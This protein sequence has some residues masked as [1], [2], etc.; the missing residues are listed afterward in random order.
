MI[1]KRNSL[2]KGVSIAETVIALA[3][4]AVVS[5]MAVTVSVT[6]V[7]NEQKNLRDFEIRS[8]CETAI[9]CFDFADDYSNFGRLFVTAT[10]VLGFNENVEENYYEFIV[11]KQN[12]KLILKI[13]RDTFSTL[14][15][16]AKDIDDVEIYQLTYTK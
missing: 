6:S 10:D 15:I 12:F 1:K 11:T 8:L 13:T 16:V 4:I 5:L 3:V 9:E 2:K 14:N 7:K